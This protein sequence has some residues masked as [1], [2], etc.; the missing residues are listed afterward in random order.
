MNRKDFGLW[1]LEL[2]PADFAKA[3]AALGVFQSS[4][5]YWPSSLSV[6]TI[7][8]KLIKTA[9]KSKNIL[10]WRLRV[11]PPIELGKLK[12][13]NTPHFFAQA[14]EKFAKAH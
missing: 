2:K 4:I 10:P 8:Q 5:D 11:V 14:W 1:G 6:D 7:G 13:A 9:A 12:Q 3:L